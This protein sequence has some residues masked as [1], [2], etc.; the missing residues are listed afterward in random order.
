MTKEDILKERRFEF[1]FEGIRYWDLLR[2]GLNNA[3]T[4]IA[5][6]QAVLSGNAADQV[7]IKAENI[8]KT[9]GF[10]QIPNTQITLSNNVLKQNSGW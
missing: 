2:Q 3:A 10:M 6:T 8:T 7:V 9:R 4:A 5:Q 1:A